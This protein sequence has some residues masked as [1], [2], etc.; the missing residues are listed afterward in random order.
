MVKN[1]R[2]LRLSKNISQQQLADVIGVTQQSINKYENHS[3]E[4]DIDTLVKLADYFETSVDFLIGHTSHP[5]QQT[6]SEDWT[7]TR[8]ETSLLKDYRQLSREEKESIRLILKNYLK[9]KTPP[10]IE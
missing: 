10:G 8:E 9:D 1:L 4:P 7:L 6:L 3:T 5:D 2:N